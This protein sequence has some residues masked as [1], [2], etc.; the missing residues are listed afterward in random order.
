MAQSPSR[1][2][3]LVDDS[4]SAFPTERFSEDDV[5]HFSIRDLYMR[6]CERAAIK[7]NT[8][9]VA[10]LPAAKHQQHHVMILDCNST[11]LGNR[12]VAAL[13]PVIAACP[14]ITHVFFSRVGMKAA[15]A[16]AL[17]ECLAVH[18]GVRAVN[19]SF[20]ELGTKVGEALR[21]FVINHRRV[22]HVD[23]EETL[24]IQPIKRRIEA[25]LAENAKIKDSF[26][27][28]LIPDIE[29]EEEAQLKK[30]RAEEERHRAEREERVRR[31]L[32]E[33]IPTLA[34]V[35]L[36]ELSEVLFILVVIERV[37][38]CEAVFA[39]VTGVANSFS[40]LTPCELAEQ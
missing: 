12:G 28:P 32:A 6:T 34:P 20:N 4:C 15:S 24:L 38:A 9:V 10:Q 17:I 3:P 31:E 18:P 11:Y 25:Q 7:P 37:L 36:T 23:M 27:V 21:Q 22:Y 35:A 19:L 14:G 16:L 1:S 29:T 30:L 26:D 2:R 13:I 33:K 8:A 5:Y 40:P 39:F